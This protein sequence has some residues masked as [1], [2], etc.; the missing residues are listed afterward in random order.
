[1]KLKKQ[2]F[3]N[4]FI[5]VIFGMGVIFL[6]NQFFAQKGID[7]RVGFNAI[8]VLVSGFL[9]LPGVVMLYGVAAIPIL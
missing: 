6:A 3:V 4:F 9:G 8:S 2:F 5:R 1:M 7:V